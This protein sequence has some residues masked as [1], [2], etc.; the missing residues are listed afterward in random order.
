VSGLR[1][2]ILTLGLGLSLAG[3][4]APAFYCDPGGAP[5]VDHAPTGTA[6]ATSGASTAAS[7]IDGDPGTAWQGA[8]SGSSVFTWEASADVF[9]ERVHVSGYF[10]SVFVELLDA[11]NAVLASSTLTLSGGSPVLGIDDAEGLTLRKVRLTLTPG[12]IPPGFPA[13]WIFELRVEM[14]GTPPPP[15][16]PGPGPEE[17]SAAAAFQGVGDGAGGAFLSRA[18]GVSPD[19]RLVVGETVTSSG[20]QA[21]RF[22]EG[23]LATLGSSG[24]IVVFSTQLLA[25]ACVNANQSRAF[26]ASNT[27]YAVGQVCNATTCGVAGFGGGTPEVFE[28]GSPG[29]IFSIGSYASDLTADGAEISGMYNDQNPFLPQWGQDNLFRLIARRYT[30]LAGYSIGGGVVTQP[31]ISPEG[32]CIVATVNGGGGSPNQTAS[33]GTC[34]T[35]PAETATDVSAGGTHVVGSIG[36]LAARGIEVLGD[37]PGGA[38]SSRALGVSDD[39]DTVV[40]WGTTAAGEEAFVWTP[41]SGIQRLADVLASQGVDLTGWTLVR[42]TGVSASG[43]TIVGWGANPGAQTEGFVATLAAPA[44]VPVLGPLGSALSALLL[45]GLGGLARRRR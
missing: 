12:T 37:L 10:A 31:R 27:G 15:P 26:A 13:L 20:L 24:S 7:A 9:V 8:T 42:A 41:A 33:F 19:G 18:H 11:A 32:D 16:L 17:L 35:L 3:R 38:D 34:G 45:L 44:A 1:L 36:G 29:I 25:Y 23:A 22:A 5:P 4:P 39:G 6:S 14:A 21:F 40:G 28:P 43:R 30:V 2:P